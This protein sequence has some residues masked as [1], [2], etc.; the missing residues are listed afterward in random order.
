MLQTVSAAAQTHSDFRSALLWI[1]IVVVLGLILFLRVWP[2]RNRRDSRPTEHDKPLG[3]ANPGNISPGMRAWR[4]R[5][6]AAG[7]GDNWL[8]RPL[9]RIDTTENGPGVQILPHEDEPGSQ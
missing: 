7:K 5:R 6:A 8:T 9:I 1:L 3:A 2:L 4:R